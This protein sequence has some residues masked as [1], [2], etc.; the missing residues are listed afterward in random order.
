MQLLLPHL[1][2]D[3][4]NNVYFFYNCFALFLSS[5]RERKV[6]EGKYLTQLNIPLVKK[7]LERA[8]LGKCPVSQAVLHSEGLSSHLPHCRFVFCRSLGENVSAI[9]FRDKE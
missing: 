9:T 8:S 2:L 6:G 5:L 4:S 1:F 7:I 3:F